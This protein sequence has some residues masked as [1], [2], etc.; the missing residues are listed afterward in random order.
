MMANVD[1]RTRILVAERAGNFCEYCRTPAEFSTDD[2]AVEHVMP[3]SRGGTDDIDNLAWSCQGC[4]SRK[5]TAIEGL[6]PITGSKTPLFDPRSD[7]WA[8]HF[9][10]SD[11]GL[12]LLGRTPVG[13]A[14]IERL[15]LNRLGAVN[16]RRGRVALGEHP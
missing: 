14:T 15:E 16:I 4:N 6:D 7:L 5:F 8:E 10:W 11:D 9:Q 12:R 1:R 13:R 2:F 3:K